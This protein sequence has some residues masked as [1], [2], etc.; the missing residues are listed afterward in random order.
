MKI[1]FSMNNLPENIKKHY[2][3]LLKKGV[4]PRFGTFNGVDIKAPSW[5]KHKWQEWAIKNKVY[6][7]DDFLNIAK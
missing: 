4:L 1:E 7:P 5:S 6:L 3:R 2:E